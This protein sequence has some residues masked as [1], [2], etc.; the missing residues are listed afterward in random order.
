[1]IL[2]RIDK[3]ARISKLGNDELVKLADEIRQRI[4]EV[5]ARNGGHIAPSLG[6]VDLTLALLSVFDPL[7][8]RVVWDVG[9]QSYA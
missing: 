7:K 6:T 9:H 2:E 8:D 1:M 4:I 3:P 5:V